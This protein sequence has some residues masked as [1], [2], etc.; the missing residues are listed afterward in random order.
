MYLNPI[1]LIHVVTHALGRIEGLPVQVGETTCSMVFMVVNTNSYDILLGF[2]FL[3]KI[4]TI[5]DVEK[6]LI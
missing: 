5:V 1:Q 3:I 6:G 2:D 4:G